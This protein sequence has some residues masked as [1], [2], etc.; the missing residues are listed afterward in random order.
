M[1]EAEGETMVWQ[2]NYS[3][4]FIGGEWV[5]PLSS[6]RIQVT[7]PYTEQVLAEVPATSRED[8]NKAVAAA[9]TAF[10][11]GEWPRTSPDERIAAVSRL[12]EALSA[13]IELVASVVSAE[14]GCPISLA[15][16]FQALS[17]KSAAD[18]FLELAPEYPFSS[19][20]HH[21][22]G[23]ALV[24]REPVG[25]VA[26]VVPWNVPVTIAMMKLVPALLAGC[27]VIL[28]PASESPLSSYLLAEMIEEA[29]LPE[30]VVSILPAE[31]EVSEYLISHSGVD[32]VAFTGSSAVGRRIAS[33]CGQDLRRVTLELGGKSAA[34]I[35]PDADLQVTVD[36]LKKGSFL[37]SG[38]VCSLKT[39]LLVPRELETSF[40]DALTAMVSA[41][42]VGDPSDPATEIGPLITPRQRERVEGYIESGRSEGAEIVVGG[43]RPE[44]QQRGWFVEPTIFRGVDT[45]MR[46]AQEEIFGPV[47]A[48][49]VYDTED[50]AV[51]IA[52][53]SAYGLNGSVF[54]DDVE[55][56]MQV[57][58]RIRSGTV[59]LNGSPAGRFAPMGGFKSSGIGRELGVEG[60][61]AYTELKSI[62]LPP[63]LANAV[64]G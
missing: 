58:K 22:T 35:L 15:Q 33:I 61:D 36:A 30:G 54:S 57:A 23:N 6:D 26:A 21:S 48:V 12:A 53:D 24:V 41:L 27:C 50:E 44:A 34:I 55:H 40:L 8:V 47:V 38:Q 39:R 42:S 16:T 10:D 14:M 9:R 52:N 63:A 13:R 3:Q 46:I 25:V 37:N 28:K 31:R 17:A 7:S 5:A 60:F 49:M 11:E 29:G 45:T 56:G 20:R 19:I 18:A 43:G 4:L 59:E 2:G 62:G 64:A 32:K 51:A 1:H